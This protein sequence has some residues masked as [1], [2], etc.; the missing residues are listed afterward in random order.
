MQNLLRVIK[1]AGRILSR[2]WTKVH[3]IFGRHRV[4]LVVVNALARLCISYFV[5]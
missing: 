3:D 5:P 4:P 2:L 1:N